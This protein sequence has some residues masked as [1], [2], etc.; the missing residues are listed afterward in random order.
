MQ[1]PFVDLKAQYLALKSEIDAGIFRVLDHGHYIMGPEVKECEEKLA[2]FTGAKHALVCSNGSEALM[3]ALMALGLKAG[4]EIITTSFSFIATIEMPVVLGI[5]PVLVDIDLESYNIDPDLIENAI[6]EKTRAI[7]PVS[8]YGLPAD[9]ERINAIAKKHNLFVIEDGAQS[10]GALYQGRRSCHLSEIGCTSF[11]PAKPLGCFGDGGAVFTDDDAL[12]KAMASIRVH[13]S[14]E[15]RYFHDRVGL[16]GRL[17]SM[18]CAVLSAKMARYPW[19]L[20]ARERIAQKYNEAFRELKSFG[21]RTPQVPEQSQSVWAQY[22][23]WMPKR[24]QVQKALSEK[25][26]PTA[27][28]YPS[29]MY[30]QPAYK[31]L[32]RLAGQI[33]NARAAAEHVLSLP[34]YPDM[35]EQISDYVIDSVRAAVLT[36]LK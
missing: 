25:G 35:T 2:Q 4:D 6:T 23:L 31:D 18:Q 9:F 19:E 10:F 26:V 12:A 7:M 32:C 22:T 14:L 29:T 1:V 33:E 36:T 17:D 11:F 28:H 20:S 27:I 13:G 24:A 30:D 3:M 34:M 15:R 5:K 8:L 16:N 21:V